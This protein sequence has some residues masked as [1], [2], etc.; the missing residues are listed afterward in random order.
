MKGTVIAFGCLMVW[1]LAKACL[2]ADWVSLGEG[3]G[4]QFQI[5]VD[6]DSIRKNGARVTVVEKFTYRTPA[7]YTQG[8]LIYAITSNQAYDC[9]NRKTLLLSGAAYSDADATVAIGTT[10]YTD[11]PSNYSSVIENSV[12]ERVLNMVCT[13]PEEVR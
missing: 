8:R 6:L 10:R 12:E 11:D 7:R 9:E 2:A 5:A 3:G 1:S 4:S 13:W